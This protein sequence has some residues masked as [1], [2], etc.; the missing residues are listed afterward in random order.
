[1]VATTDHVRL[2]LF[3]SRQKRSLFSNDQKRALDRNYS[4]IVSYDG[5]CDMNRSC[6][7]NVQLRPLWVVANDVAQLRV[8]T[9]TTRQSLSGYD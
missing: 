1:M 4:M 5:L 7:K 3:L 6:R 9:L 2:R 8:Y